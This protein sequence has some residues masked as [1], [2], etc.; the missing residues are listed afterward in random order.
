M[1]WVE[2]LHIKRW[3]VITIIVVFV[4]GLGG[5]L[6]RGKLLSATKENAKDAASAAV[7]TATVER[8][9]I[10][11][12]IDATGTIKPLNVVAVNSKASGKILKLA[13]DAGDYVE[14]GAVIARIETTYVQSD[15]EQA[16]AD[17]RASKAR[18]DQAETNIKL[19][20]EQSGIQIAQAEES[21]QEARRR[22]EQLTEQNRI[23]KQANERQVA[24]AENNLKMAE[25]RLKLQ[26]S[27]GVRTESIKRAE[28]SVN[29]AKAS[30]DLAEK[31]Y[32]RKKALFEKKFISKA[33]LDAAETQLKSAEAQY[34]SAVEQVEIVRKPSSET[35]LALA[36]AELEKAKFVQKAALEQVEAQKYRDMELDLQ[37]NRVK[38]AEESLKLANANKAQITLK[39]KDLE[40]AKA[41]LQRSEVQLKLANDRLKDTVI[42]APISGTILE[43]RVE[44]GQVITSSLSSVVSSQGTTLVTM[45]DLSK[46]Y[47][48]TTVDETDIGQVKVG[49]PVTIKVEAYPD[50][51]FEGVVLKIA[52]Q[53]QVVQN[54]TTFEVT[55][56]LTNTGSRQR[57]RGPG[58][59][60]GRQWGEG[61]PPMSG[62]G[63]GEGNRGGFRPG[64][65]E[66][67]TPE[68]RERWMAMRRQREGGNSTDASP[69]A[70]TAETA[71]PKPQVTQ[72]SAKKSSEGGD[73]WDAFLDS[74][75]DAG[76]KPVQQPVEE[77]PTPFL[78]PGMN[79]SVE[80]A[81][82]NKQG[83]LLIPNE[84]ILSFGSRKMVRP[85]GP[86]GAPGR[87]QPIVAGVSG[88]DK[89]EVVSGV[90][91]GQVVAVG[92]FQPGAGGDNQQWRRM[93]QNPASTM[94]RMQGGGPGGQRGGSG[95][96]RR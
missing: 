65:G 79:A 3:M 64:G 18:L 2:R 7:K 78:K 49:Q 26:T 37:R 42:T 62:G 69:R 22:L 58:S 54:V 38:Q 36:Q 66:S 44:E 21:L 45:A 28:S 70:A 84:A 85:I 10:Q 25:L 5:F 35:E 53:G 57:G 92:G 75:S 96:G 14:E 59:Q 31:E 94:R 89:T 46:V 40:S 86:D 11:A 30:R 71:Q 4:L 27:E 93:M 20:K 55:T 76:Q 33:D 17:L 50:Q 34:Q 29:Q 88:F 81:L 63:Q 74:F 41:Q 91:E 47:V 6:F 61:A 67:A 68:Q 19:Q 72:E 73:P 12:T 13:V 1:R 9:D 77:K 87:P 43:K 83:V 56:E 82:A 95:G 80:I 24:D 32:E 90:E 48:I 39:E 15:V 8:G 23:E 51:P 52:P 16:E 60:G